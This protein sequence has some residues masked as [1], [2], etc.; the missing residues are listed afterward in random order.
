MATVAFIA[1][2]F[3]GGVYVPRF[4]L[5]DAITRIGVYVPPGVQALHDG[6]IGTAPPQVL[7]LLIMAGIALVATAA[8]ARLF[9][10][11]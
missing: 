4:L 6:W 10:W 2:M 3:F 5:P 7:H 11:E 1:V 8:A 9:R